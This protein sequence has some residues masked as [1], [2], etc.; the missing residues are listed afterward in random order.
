MRCKSAS[1]LIGLG[2]ALTTARALSAVPVLVDAVFF[3]GPGDQLPGYGGTPIAAGENGIYTCGYGQWSGVG[4]PAIGLHYSLPPGPMPL[5]SQPW[6]DATVKPIGYEAFQ[7]VTATDEGVYFAG[8]GYARTSDG[9]GDKETKSVLVKYALDGSLQWE[10]L[11]NFYSYRGGESFNAVTDALEG[12]NRVI[13]AGGNAQAGFYNVTALVAKYDTAG[14][15]LW[16]R[17]VGD[18]SS[19]HSNTVMGIAVLEGDIYGAGHDAW[20][21]WAHI[22]LWK[23]ASDGLSSSTL[24]TYSATPAEAR[25]NGIATQGN[26]LYVAGYVDPGP[27]GGKDALILKY[28]ASGDLIWHKEWGGPAEEEA[29][30]IATD[31]S[32]IYVVGNTASSGAGGSDAFLITLDPDTGEVISET[33]YGGAEDDAAYGCVLVG[34]DLYVSGRSK[35]F[36]YN[37][38]LIGKDDMMLLRY[39]SDSDDDGVCDSVDN[40]P[41]AYNPDQA[42]EDDDGV[43]DACD[44]CPTVYN[45]EQGD[46]DKDGIGDVCDNCPN[47]TNPDQIDSDGDGVGD[48][49]DQ[50]PDSPSG[51]WVNRFTGCPTSRADL[52]RDGDVDMDDFGI[53][54]RC[55]SGPEI[56]ADASCAD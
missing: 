36:A 33:Y 53:F 3:G 39:C 1:V 47:V 40:C 48:A 50:C 41:T 28:D 15:M 43:G 25:S 16:W 37:G 23:C 45:P 8:Y 26:S 56:P 44:N 38:N 10:A 54:Q 52:D 18:T 46:S 51:S 22:K 4:Y 13:Y 6:P 2:V 49:C 27:N 7:A 32:T 30:G 55:Y 14:N 29:R 11:P 42:D 19:Y 12:G 5:W 31:S 35:S 34:S 17:P 21:G 9:V 20:T 24:A